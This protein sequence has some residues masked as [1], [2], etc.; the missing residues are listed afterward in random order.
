[1]KGSAS[2]VTALRERP[3]LWDRAPAAD[4]VAF[5]AV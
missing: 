4:Q 5:N 3:A 2:D 1:M